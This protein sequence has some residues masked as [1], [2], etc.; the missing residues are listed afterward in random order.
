MEKGGH[1]NDLKFSDSSLRIVFFFSGLFEKSHV[2]TPRC[3]RIF[4]SS[5]NLACGWQQKIP[6]TLDDLNP[7][8]LEFQYIELC[9]TGLVTRLRIEP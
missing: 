6:A 7:R 5:R 3:R 1:E 2:L 8:V 9:P 4:S